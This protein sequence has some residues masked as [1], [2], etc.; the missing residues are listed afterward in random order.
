[1]IPFFFFFFHFPL[2]FDLDCAVPLP[3]F[4]P[5]KVLLN[6]QDP[7]QVIL[8]E[9]TSWQVQSEEVL[10]ASLIASMTSLHVIITTLDDSALLDSLRAGTAVY[11]SLYVP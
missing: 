4:V 7:S 8:S 1:M 2:L 9:P 3:F 5:W 11:C 6:L 10:G